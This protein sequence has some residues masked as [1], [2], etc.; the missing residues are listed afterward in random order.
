[1][2]NVLD[3][4]IRPHPPIRLVI[5][6]QAD[7]DARPKDRALLRVLRQ[8]IQAGQRV[9]RNGRTNPLD[10]IAV[11]IVMRR[12]D[13]DEMED[14]HL[15]RRMFGCCHHYLS[16]T[17]WPVSCHASTSWPVIDSITPCRPFSPR[18]AAPGRLR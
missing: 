1:A 9:G 16:A 7:I 4:A 15:V 14:T 3:D 6:V 5:G 2:T 10:R 18:P 12:L 11:V 8:A 13:H 17:I